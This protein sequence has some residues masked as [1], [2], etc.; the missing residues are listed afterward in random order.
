MAFITAEEVK[1][2]RQEL[3]ATFPKVK[4]SVVRRDRMEVNVSILKS[5]MDFDLDNSTDEC[6]NPYNINEFYN[7]EQAEFLNKV[8]DIIK[9]APGSIDGGRKYHDRSDP[10][11]DYF[12]VAYYYEISIGKWDK[13]YELIK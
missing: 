1:A 9:T 5:D 8:H 11:T 12:D 7:G 2:I 3:K 6:V 13:P 10:Q 4:F